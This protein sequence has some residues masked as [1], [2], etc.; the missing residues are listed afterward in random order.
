MCGITGLYNYRDTNVGATRDRVIRMSG[1]IAHRG[2]DGDGCFVD[3]HG[4]IGLGHRRLSIIDLSSGHQPMSNAENTITIVFNGEIYNYQTLKR[5]LQAKGYRFR[6]S[7]DTEVV[8]AMY[9]VYGVEAF[10]KLNGIFAFALWDS[11]NARLLLVR[12]PFGVKP[13]YYSV[14]ENGIVFGSEIKSILASRLIQKNLDL[15]ALSVFLSFR[16]NPSPSTLFDGIHKL[17]PSRY[18]S[19]DRDGVSKFEY[20][21]YSP[22]TNQEIGFEAAVVQYRERIEDAVKRQLISD[23]PVGLLLSGGI[24]SAVIGSLMTR[25]SSQK[26]KS[27]TIGFEGEGD[28]NELAMA[29]E[30]A[31]IIGTD[32][33]ETVISKKEYLD[34]FLKSFYYLEEPIAITSITALYIIS[35][36]VSQH[37]KVVLCGQG[38]DE[39]LLGYGR[40]AAEKYVSK[41]APLLRCFPLALISKWY[42]TSEII[43]RLIDALRYDDELD[44]FHSIYGILKDKQTLLKPEFY[45][46]TNAAEKE[47]IGGILSGATNIQ[48]SVCR[49]AFV[50]VRFNLADSLLLLADKVSMAN[51]LELRVPFLD[52]EL[53]NFLE[54]LPTEFKLKGLNAKYIHKRAALTMF[55]STIVNRK[56]I[57]FATPVGE[58]LRNDLKD[59][60][61]EMVN[62]QSSA[63]NT[64]FDKNEV[65][66]IFKAHC[67][68]ASDNERKLFIILSFEQWYQNFYRSI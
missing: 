54:S 9:Q 46:D 28:F 39:P 45:R 56:K 14:Y 24:D 43:E 20:Q 8:I 10:K 59:T 13:L 37:V 29:R 34:Y 65:M 63:A 52:H 50:D 61:L 22:R 30:T 51:S 3:E 55:S 66:R 57:G 48:D 58:W 47:I 42:N 62:N 12:D 64:F 6:T 4:R 18:L 21:I 33:Y 7:S 53:M 35:K 5:E 49:M 25:N 17:E 1:T 23:V 67:E 11:V 31:G 38:A 44:R 32:H 68:R 27:F 36:I 40:Y 16:F 19:V 60:F 41:Y 2:P 15:E 26:I